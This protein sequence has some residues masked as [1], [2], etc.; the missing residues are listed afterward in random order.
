MNDIM[1]LVLMTTVLA[2]GGLG[3][4][5]YKSSDENQKGGSDYNEDELFN[6]FNNTIDENENIDDEI[7]Q[8][9][10]KVKNGK[11]KRNRRSNTGTKRRYLYG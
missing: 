10:I 3:L 7:Y 9:K 1:S 11:T 6:S 2:A 4:Y 8:S 5:M